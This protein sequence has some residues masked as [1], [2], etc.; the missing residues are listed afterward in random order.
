M[1]LGLEG[2]QGL[3][4]LRSFRL[5]RVFKLAKSWPTLNMLISIVART[6]GALGNLT[7][8]LGIIVFIFAV[9]GQQLFGES[10]EKPECFEDNQ[11]P[12]WGF[13]TFLHSFMIVFRVLCG[14]WIESMWTCMEVSGYACVPFFLLTMIIGNLVTGK[15]LHIYLSISLSIYLSS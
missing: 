7:L 9:M 1:E 8:V 13:R 10:Y 11:I 12:R 2:I 15:P 3:S 5:L 14:E 6:M 4:V